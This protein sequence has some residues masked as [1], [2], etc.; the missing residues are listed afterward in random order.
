[1][2]IVPKLLKGVWGVEEQKF[3]SSTLTLSDFIWQFPPVVW[4]P[5]VDLLN[6]KG[7][8]SSA[9]PEMSNTNRNGLQQ[10]EQC[11]VWESR[12]LTNKGE[13]VPSDLEKN[14]IIRLQT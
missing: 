5:K 11:T 13:E 8:F 2:I 12:V 10:M 4:Q 9:S 3:T 14:I 7:S 1:M 6:Q